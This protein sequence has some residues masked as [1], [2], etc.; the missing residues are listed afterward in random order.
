MDMELR[1]ERHL[2]VLRAPQLLLVLHGHELFQLQLSGKEKR[3]MRLGELAGRVRHQLAT[4]A[5]V[6]LWREYLLLAVALDD[7]VEFYQMPQQAMLD[8]R[9]LLFEPIQEFALAGS[10]LQQLH[11]L[12]PNADQV[13][14][15]LTFNVTQSQAR[16]R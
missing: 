7:S 6:V 2:L 5:A 13:L 3:L 15:L 16:C 10:S 4:A 14:L 9:Q 11:L 12:Q 8:A 1:H